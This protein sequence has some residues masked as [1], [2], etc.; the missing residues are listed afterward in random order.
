[1]Y[2]LNAVRGSTVQAEPAAAM[3]LP[4]VTPGKWMAR[5]SYF[6]ASGTGLFLLSPSSSW[7]GLGTWV[8]PDTIVVPGAQREKWDPAGRAESIT[9]EAE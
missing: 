7:A 5:V 3:P 9:P 1:M 6:C 2:V 8:A 4:S